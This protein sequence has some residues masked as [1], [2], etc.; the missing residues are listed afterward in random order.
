MHDM[1]RPLPSPWLSLQYN[2]IYIAPCHPPPSRANYRC[3]AFPGCLTHWWKK[4]WK[5]KHVSL[6]SSLYGTRQLWV[7][8][9]CWV[10]L[11]P[12]HKSTIAPHPPEPSPTTSEQWNT[13]RFHSWISGRGFECIPI[14]SQRWDRK[15]PEKQLK[16]KKDGKYQVNTCLFGNYYDYKHFNIAVHHSHVSC[17]QS[18]DDLWQT[19]LEI[20]LRLNVKSSSDA[21]PPVLTDPTRVQQW[22]KAVVED[23]N[24]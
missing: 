12:Y 10:L 11:V 17:A 18:H 16:Q 19:S 4:R 5:M 20:K 21:V 8:C 7:R 15:V 9:C 14:S 3:S 2:R 22:T 13:T 6:S 24:H 1:H 23:S